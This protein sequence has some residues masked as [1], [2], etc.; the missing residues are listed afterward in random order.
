MR[1]GVSRATSYHASYI[2]YI[3]DA[4]SGCEITVGI[5]PTHIQ[6]GLELKEFHAARTRCFCEVPDGAMTHLFFFF[7]TIIIIIA[8]A[9]FELSSSQHHPQ[10]TNCSHA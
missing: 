2:R 4:T 6:F 7:K 10:K 1:F 5:L 3:R 8:S 9:A